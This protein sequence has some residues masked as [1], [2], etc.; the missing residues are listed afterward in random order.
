ML[1][2]FACLALVGAGGFLA[3]GSGGTATHVIGAALL[4][5][6][7]ALAGWGGV[8]LQGAKAMTA[9]PHPRGDAELAESGAYRLVRHPIYGGLI[10][11]ALGWG[12]V[13]ASVPALA[14]AALLA[15]TLDLKRRR[16]EAWLQERFA[17]Y[18]AYRTRTRALL[19][20]VY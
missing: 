16:E 9:L 5:G 17:G 2:Q 4:I 7:A 18:A 15:I 19:P 6:G 20:F 11:L 12:A 1:L 14:A 8:T 3:P 13:T 10:L